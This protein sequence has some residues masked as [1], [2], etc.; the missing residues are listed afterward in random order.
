[1]VCM[2]HMRGAQN[3]VPNSNPIKQATDFGY[4]GVQIFFVISGF[5]IPWSLYNEG[6]R[7]KNFFSYLLKRIARI[8]P[9]YIISIILVLILNFLSTK[10][11]IYAGLPFNFDLIQ[12]FLHFLYLPNY[13]GYQ[14][15]QPVYYTLLIEFQ[16]Y[17]IIGLIFPLL[18][19]SKKTSLVYLIIALAVGQYV[20]NWGLFGNISLFLVGIVYFKYR[21]N[22]INTIQFW[23]LI[24]LVMAFTFLNDPDKYI[25]VSEFVAVIGIIYWNSGTAIS[26]FLGKIS[27]SLYLIHI[28]IGGRIMNLGQHYS[29]SIYLSY[30]LFL[31]AIVASII[32]A[33][34]FY[35]FVEL[36]SIKLSKRVSKNFK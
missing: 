28:P 3:F 21:I 23:L 7:L 16:F 14:W 25:T 12:F 26:Q 15:L 6:Y 19:I 29:H 30:F 36:P 22:H 2:Y 31:I 9:P 35:Q 34:I 18:I 20:L 17:I 1:M 8:E 10:S 27:Y 13:L 11:P 4:L 24:L 33:S 32:C 5:V